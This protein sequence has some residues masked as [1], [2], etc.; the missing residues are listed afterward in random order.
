[1][2]DRLGY[3]PLGQLVQY[4]LLL[5][6]LYPPLWYHIVR[7][8]HHTLVVRR[9]PSACTKS[10]LALELPRVLVHV[11]KQIVP[12]WVRAVSPHWWHSWLLFRWVLLILSPFCQ[13]LVPEVLVSVVLSNA[14]SHHWIHNRAW[15]KRCT[16][17]FRQTWLVPWIDRVIFWRVRLG[18][19]VVIFLCLLLYPFKEGYSLGR[20]YYCLD[21]RLQLVQLC[22]FQVVL[23]WRWYFSCQSLHICKKGLLRFELPGIGQF[24]LSFG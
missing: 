17:S 3:H 22:V 6:V 4:V 18:A 11:L 7:H 14:W 19:G 10:A 20:F 16:F 24:P 12:N 15:Y 8:I 13:S 1:M 23:A 5:V 9:K 2:I 21:G